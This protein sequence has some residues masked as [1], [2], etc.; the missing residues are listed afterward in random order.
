MK[1]M[2]ILLALAL[3]FGGVGIWYMGHQM[4]EDPGEF[5]AFAFGNPKEDSIDMEILVTVAMPR[6][7]WARVDKVTGAVYWQEWVDEH[8]DIRDDNDEKVQLM[9]SNHSRFIS[10]AEARTTPE[11]YLRGTLKPNT[12]YTFDYIPYRIG[13]LKYRYDFVAPAKEQPTERRVFELLEE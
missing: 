8:F 7:E 13:T 9:R 2:L 4:S 5:I 6:R 1:G 12:H 10:A 11:F 3:A